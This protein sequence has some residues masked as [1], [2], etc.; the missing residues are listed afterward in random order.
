MG[1]YSIHRVVHIEYRQ[2]GG[3]GGDY[4]C[5]IVLVHCTS[6]LAKILKLQKNMQFVTLHILTQTWDFMI[7]SFFPLPPWYKLELDCDWLK[8]TPSRGF[9]G[10]ICFFFHS[11]S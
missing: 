9:T 7:N 10:E 3:G 8:L 2:G 4:I 11:F 1:D 6:R 5:R